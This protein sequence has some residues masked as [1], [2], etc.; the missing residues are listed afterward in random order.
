M[1][2]MAKNRG[3]SAAGPAETAATLAKGL[4][5]PLLPKKLSVYSQQLSV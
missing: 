3:H 1:A 5:P 2:G 4:P